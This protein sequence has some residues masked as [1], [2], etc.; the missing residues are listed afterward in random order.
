[1]LR[2]KLLFSGLA[3]LLLF[4]A[5]SERPTAEEFDI[6]RLQPKI[7]S[8]IQKVQ[9]AV[10]AISNRPWPASRAEIF[11]GVLVSKEGHILTA[12]HAVRPNR[13]YYV[14]LNDGRQ[15]RTRG[16]GSNRRIDMAM[17]KIESPSDLPFAQM[18]D[19][20]NL[21]KNQPCVGVSHPG[22]YDRNRGPVIRFGHIIQA[23]TRN[24]GM[25]KSTAKMEPG[26]SGGPLVDID[27]K[28]IGIHS[29]IR[30]DEESNF[31]VPVNSFIKHWDELKEPEVFYVDGYPSLPKLGFRG[32]ASREGIKILKV[33]EGGQADK[34]GLKKD[35]VVTS[36]GGSKITS[37]RQFRNR[38]FDF[39]EK[40]T[41]EV[42]ANVERGGK[43]KAI[44]FKL[45]KENQVSPASYVELENL[46][47]EF[48]QLE[49]KLDD[50]IFVVRSTFGNEK[51]SVRSTLLKTNGRG[52]LVS[53]SSRVGE[54]PRV[55]LPGGRLIDAQVIKR[56]FKNDL[57]L[58][59]AKIP[60]GGGIDLRQQV[61]GDMEEK[62]GKFLLTPHPN[63]KGKI[64]VWGSKYFSITRTDASG[65]YLGVAIRQDGNR[66]YFSNVFNGA[67]KV[68]V[69]KMNDE[70][71]K[72]D[73][74]EVT[75]SKE[76]I[77]FLKSKDP[78]SKIVAVILRDNKRITKTIFLGSRGYKTGHVADDLIGG[79][80]SRRD[81]FTLAI[82][83]DGDIRPEECGSPI[84]DLNGQF[85]GINM[86]RASRVRTYV[87]P[88]TIIKR[89]VDS[90]GQ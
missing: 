55:E 51:I 7:Y 64:S 44:R 27:G 82:S 12:G 72:L 57:V 40:G 23:V 61:W 78:N 62:P 34:F 77:R 36:I 84:F 30:R 88:K 37:T 3:I 17:L 79:K 73:E 19:S 24:E 80:S 9:P 13:T 49:S 18:G 67:A 43:T 29:N 66:V 11:S 10:V 59:Q 8:A 41:A 20:S 46:P 22:L 56:D 60:G 71:L 58:L 26:D 90:A 28:V 83:H 85:M 48:E 15:F 63:S 89:F 6:N 14:I 2:I 54:K 38:L 75:N 16:L 74:M 81:G 47:G 35:D 32:E 1:M 31:D 21:V 39:N 5:G 53:K 68:A 45:K 86:A 65:G 33:V 69:V 52:N 25:I 87:V 70:L 76:A 42:F 4:F 50:D